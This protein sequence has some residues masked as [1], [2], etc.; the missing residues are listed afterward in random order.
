LAAFANFVLL[1]PFDAF[2]LADFFSTPRSVS[3]SELFAERFG[4]VLDERL[5]LAAFAAFA[6][7]RVPDEAFFVE[8]FRAVRA[9]MDDCDLL[10]G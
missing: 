2:N 6:L 1:V 9:A 4:V 10:V 7:E 8:D 3:R 5:L